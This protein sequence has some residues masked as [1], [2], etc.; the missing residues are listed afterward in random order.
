M[1]ELN[2]QGSYQEGK[3][4]TKARSKKEMLQQSSISKHFAEE[5]VTISQHDFQKSAPGHN[6]DVVLL[7]EE[8]DV[9]YSFDDESSSSS[10][11]EVE[12]AA[13]C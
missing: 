2:D 11:S 10:S 8:S 1:S 7:Q 9:V 12:N 13:N 6:Q 5:E 4:W 3:G